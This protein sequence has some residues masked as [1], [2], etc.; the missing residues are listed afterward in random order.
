MGPGP[1]GLVVRS[2]LPVSQEALR[3]RRA[4]IQPGSRAYLV[5]AASGT[6]ASIPERIS[7]V[8]SLMSTFV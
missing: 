8:R 1:A 7:A 4:S 3:K 6:L 2:S 5:A